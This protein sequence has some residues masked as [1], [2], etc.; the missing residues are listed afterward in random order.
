MVYRNSEGYADPTAGAALS[1]RL[2]HPLRFVIHVKP[3]TKKNHQRIVKGGN[4]HF[5]VPSEQYKQFLKECNRA[6]PD[7]ARQEI[8][9]PVNVKAVYYV[10]AA[11]RVDITNLESALM[12]VLVAA[13]VLKDD[14]AIAPRI[15][16]S[17]D[18]SRVHVDRQ[19]P[20]IEVE[21]TPV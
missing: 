13:E 19:K 10:D 4:R 20:R 14:S 17:T 18:G 2:N 12:D 15:V 3:R 21:I 5:I 8:D 7:Y 1:Q 9:Q 6:I 11:R 16:V